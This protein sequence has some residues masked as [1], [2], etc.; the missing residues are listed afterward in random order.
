[1]SVKK[2]G[3]STITYF[4]DKVAVVSEADDQGK[5]QVYLCFEDEQLGKIHLDGLLRMQF[6]FTIDE[7]I[8]LIG[9]LQK[10][11]A[12]FAQFLTEEDRAR[13]T[14]VMAVTESSQEQTG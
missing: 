4:P 6:A 2:A 9:E 11:C 10:S 1:M 13:I 8:T 14:E 5:R 7:V 12:W 3:K